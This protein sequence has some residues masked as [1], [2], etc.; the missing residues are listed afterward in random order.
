MTTKAVVFDVDGTLLDT[1]EFIAAAIE[2]SL[3][4]HGHVVPERKQVVEAATGR[5]LDDCYPLLAP[6]GDVVA[7]R[8]TH[9]AFQMKRFD[10]VNAYAG[11]HE[12][13]TALRARGILLGICSIR[14]PNLRPTLEH[15]QALAYFDA[16]VDSTGVTNHKPHPEGILKVLELLNVAPEHAVA[17]GDTASDIE[18]GKA[19]GC[20]LTIAITHGLGTRESLEKSGADHI[21]TSLPDILPFV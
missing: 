20:S 18:A 19:A 3:R 13:L 12:V 5:S 21:V 17:I 1:R 15:T 4:A 2:H 14:G 9:R 7:L 11:M 6:D 8:D 10:L 16:I